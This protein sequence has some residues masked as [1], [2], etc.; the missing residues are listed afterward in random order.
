[1]RSSGI[2]KQAAFSAPPILGILTSRPEGAR[3][4]RV[5]ALEAGVVFGDAA[6]GDPSESDG[7]SS[8]EPVPQKVE[9]LFRSAE[10]GL[11][12]MF[13]QPQPGEALGQ[14][15]N[16]TPQL[17]ARGREHQYIVHV[18]DEEQPRPFATPDLLCEKDHAGQ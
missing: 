2:G 9:S 5:L 8:S 11:V 18:T 10:V 15:S 3:S 16:R 12:G 7:A 4:G 6:Q 13:L 14:D 17:S 1:M